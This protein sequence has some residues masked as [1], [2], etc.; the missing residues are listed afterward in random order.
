MTL[1]RA[2]I[3]VYFICLLWQVHADETFLQ[4]LDPFSLP[5]V[6]PDG[7]D[8]NS[9]AQ[10][11]AIL[12]LDFFAYWC[13]PCVELSREID[14][15]LRAY[16]QQHPT[17][18]GL[19]VR[20]LAVNVDQRSQQRTHRFMQTAGLEHAW[21]DRNGTLLDSLNAPGLPFVIILGPEDSQGNRS[22]YHRFTGAEEID[23]LRER[24]EDTARLILSSTK[25]DSESPTEP[26][27][28]IPNGTPD[29]IPTPEENPVVSNPAPAKSATTNPITA[30]EETPRQTLPPAAPI[31]VEVQ[32]P[33]PSTPPLTSRPSKGRTI[34]RPATV[35]ETMHSDDVDL[36]QW[37][38]QW[39]VETGRWT[40]RPLLTLG[41]LEMDYVP[42]ARVLLGNP[43][44]LDD[45]RH[46][47]SQAL[48]RETDWGTLE[49][50]A[51]ASRGFQDYRSLWLAEFYRQGFSD[52]PMY[53]SITPNLYAAGLSSE[54]ILGANQGRMSLSFDYQ[55]DRVSPPYERIIPDN[56]REPIFTEVGL[57]DL[58]TFSLSGQLDWILSERDYLVSRIAFTD[59][60]ARD[61]R[62]TLDLNYKHIWA[63]RW[64][65][66][67]RA[68]AVEEGDTFRSRSAELGLER[69]WE[70]RWFLGG[71]L[72]YYTD[73][74]TVQDT[75]VV[76]AEA[77]PLDTLR[78]GLRL[79]YQ[80]DRLALSLAL[81][82]YESRYDALS[83]SSFQFENLYQDRDWKII[84]LTISTRL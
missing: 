79:I 63:D 41:T 35:F 60:T 72:R 11:N 67:L 73:Q 62:Y 74:G 53:Q 32:P 70:D 33:L 84:R 18:S 81:Y 57:T 54:W 49:F 65:G 16:Y 40:W 21:E 8:F 24:I 15:Q 80:E 82:H 61:L 4:K 55:H 22:V 10:A 59:T 66:S 19:P 43:A 23:L 34:Q 50:R 51:A 77:P 68:M 48:I 76:S 39:M 27:P 13:A 17:E 5:S 25:T 45:E 69:D 83:P 46:A 20:V 47:F 9:K 75:T 28:P 26:P 30:P 58:D 64:V 71:S 12:V 78:A 36:A 44:D 7:P 42:S 38:L 29:P 56:P 14:T 1:K 31:P 37:D 6:S 3:T 52:D 2:W